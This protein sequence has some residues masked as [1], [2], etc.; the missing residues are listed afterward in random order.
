M[1]EKGK[2]FIIDDNPY[3]AELL[4]ELLKNDNYVVSTANRGEN[5]LAEIPAVEPNLILIDAHLSDTDPF[6][7]CKQL[8]AGE[9]TRDVSVVFMSSVEDDEAR[10]KGVE[11]G[12]D[13]IMKPFEP[14]EV[15]A[16]VERQVTVSKVR[17]ALRESE[18]KFRSVMESA[19]D[20]IISGDV[21]GN[22]R[23]WNRAA[24]ALFGHTVDEAIGQ[25]IE[26]I[27][28]ERF[29]KQH[30]EGMQRVSSGGPSRVIGKTVELAALRKDGTEFPIEL[31][32]AT[33]ILEDQRYYTGIIRD[34]S[35]R[36]QA[37]QKFR[38][39]TE[40]AIDAIISADHTGKIISWNSAAT[41]ILGFTAEEVTG[42]QLEIIIPERFHE[43]H[44]QGM[45]RVTEHGDSRVIGKT[46]ELYARTKSG[47]EVPIE[48]SLSTWTVHE[49][50]YYTGIIRDISERKEAETQLRDYATQLAQQHEEM[51][52]AQAQLVETEKQAMLGRL[53]AGLLHELNTPLGALRSAGDSVAR[54]LESCHDFVSRRCDC[55]DG[56][57]EASRALR[58]L[59]LGNELSDVFSVSTHR[60]ESVINVL[61]HFVQIDG[62]ELATEDLRHV[63]D[64]AITLLASQSERVVIH[65]QYPESPAL[66]HCHPAKL[67]QAFLNVLQNALEAIDES[68]E[69][70]VSIDLRDDRVEVRMEDTG[71]GMTQDQISNAFDFKFYNK[72]GRVRLGLGLAASKRAVVE[73]GGELSVESTLGKGT[74]VIFS[75][76]LASQG[77]P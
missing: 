12:D 52:L 22:V 48:L 63:I 39:V 62:A 8:K 25:P 51:K 16:R 43:P 30:R 42:Q 53:L 70:R 46:V 36:K 32:L 75:L 72:G 74:S 38:S 1:S 68:G 20:A 58:G 77:T 56:D 73:A 19:I 29:R 7:L 67:N 13:F 10:I 18:A 28:P 49:E 59:E 66:V 21:D 41:R 40:S 15:L 71:R 9:Q 34:I 33:W 27:I 31:S 47:H 69:I 23:S 26:L 44:R 61:K 17:M 24:T 76:P 4:A 60:I 64:S 11:L 14:H 54:I 45:K 37:E 2:V 6:K 55:D 35:E 50:R 57:P 5:A 3:S 65:K